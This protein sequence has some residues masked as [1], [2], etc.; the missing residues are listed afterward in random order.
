MTPQNNTK[1]QQ[2]YLRRP[3]CP[4]ERL[5]L[6]QADVDDFECAEFIEAVM[7]NRS[8]RELELSHNL[9]GGAE[10]LNT[11]MPELTTGAEALAEMI[12]SPTIKLQVLKLDWNMLRLDG[13]VELCESLGLNH[14]L[15]DVDLSYNSLGSNGGQAL[16]K[17]LILNKTLKRLRVTNNS[18][19]ATACFT[20]CA[21]VIENRGLELVHID[22]NPICEQGAAALMLV[23]LLAGSRVSISAAKCNV[24]MRDPS[25]WFSY[26][27]PMGSYT[28]NLEDAFERAIMLMLLHAVAAHQSFL[29][30]VMEWSET[31]KSKPVSIALSQVM[32][33][34]RVAYFD[35]KQK[36]ILEKLQNIV[37]SSSN[38][39]M[40]VKLFNDVD[41]DGSGEVERGEFGDLIKSMGID[42]SEMRI[43]EIFAS[44]DM[45]QGGSIGITEFLNF[46]K[47]QKIE[48]SDRIKDMCFMPIMVEAHLAEAANRAGAKH[49]DANALPTRGLKQYIPPHTGTMRVVVVDGYVTKEIKRILSNEDREN[50]ESVASQAGGSDSNSLLRLGVE[51]GKLRLEEGL[52]LLNS[53][54]KENGDLTRSLFD[55]LPQMAS[56]DDAKR[57]I[58]QSVAKDKNAFLKLKRAVGSSLRP[59][60]GAYN[61]FYRLDLSTVMD[62]LC[63]SRLLEISA[64]QKHRREKEAAAVMFGTHILD[65]SQHRNNLCFRNEHYNRKP[66]TIDEAFASSVLPKGILEFDFSCDSR[67]TRDDNPLPDFR[68][69]KMCVN[70]GLLD[71]EEA[72][73]ALQRLM[74]MRRWSNK[75]LECDGHNMFQPDMGFANAV[76][77]CMEDFYSNMQHRNKQVRDTN[78]AEMA[79]RYDSQGRI[80]DETEDDSSDRLLLSPRF[81]PMDPKNPDDRLE[82]ASKYKVKLQR[83]MKSALMMRGEPEV[84]KKGGG[85]SSKKAVSSQPSLKGQLGG[86]ARG[87]AS[88][89][90]LSSLVSLGSSEPGADGGDDNSEVSQAPTDTDEEDNG[91]NDSGNENAAGGEGGGSVGGGSRGCDDRGAD[92][93]GDGN[94]D[95]NGV[96]FASSSDSD[97]DESSDE[98]EGD[99]VANVR[100]FMK[101][102]IAEQQAALAADLAAKM[103]KKNDARALAMQKR[104]ASQNQ[105]MPTAESGGEASATGGP[106]AGPGPGAGAGAQVVGEGDVVEGES[107]GNEAARDKVMAVEESTESAAQRLAVLL[108]SDKI[109][110]ITKAKRLL[111]TID[112]FFSRVWLWARHLSLVMHLFRGLGQKKATRHFGTFRVEAFV[113]LVNRVVDLH[114]IEC[115]FRVLSPYEVACI[116]A[117]LGWLS[118]W[119]P[120]KP[121][122][123]WELSLTRPEE[124]VV[125]KCLCELS[126]KE[127]GD[128]WIQQYFKWERKAEGMPGWNLTQPWLTEE[129]LPT[130][131]IISV[132]YYSGDCKFLRGCR[133]LVPFRKSLLALFLVDEDELVEEGFRDRP[134]AAKEGRPFM[135]MEGARWGQYLGARQDLTRTR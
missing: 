35:D 32:V 90:Q 6:N 92:G 41:E 77:E 107:N 5:V 103:A 14:T 86:P 33:D 12:R 119:N 9:L 134:P 22:G 36:R 128:N 63:F 81:S 46:L 82:N 95:G 116:Y 124:R 62:R 31:P 100:A 34:E 106:G 57:L 8:L 87:G 38:I 120:C 122:G 3:D 20:I 127:P 26:N 42:M 56:H 40:A 75:A 121:E 39:Q 18:I 109:H 19:D 69:V 130:R 50:L 133:P 97:N 23:P 64:T 47:N 13:A 85:K 72:L 10:N 104:L 43:D 66:I 99:E 117:R 105:P 2:E 29:F 114:N 4:L 1:P 84:V 15:T 88:N 118:L 51:G 27:K 68:V 110:V 102:R 126:T 98:E 91:G 131:G 123:C 55:I 17:S 52:K 7:E 60:M 59:I 53:M 74:L 132:E 112:E 111:E 16:G 37:A 83:H 45:D 28:L 125:V 25:C 54:Y 108:L 24:I 49:K 96:G 71:P 78:N 61:G 94:G 80:I 89:N 129:G 67:P 93:Q 44:Y 76:G 58:F 11:V 101:A 135:L 48:A 79:L 30:E 65:L 115:V 113:I 21:G 70:V 73:G